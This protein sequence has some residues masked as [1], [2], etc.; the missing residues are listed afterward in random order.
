MVA[1]GAGITGILGMREIGMAGR[2]RIKGKGGPSVCSGKMPV[3]TRMGGRGFV[4]AVVPV[5]NY[6]TVR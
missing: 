5:K 2:I 6:A 3:K 1:S 4:R